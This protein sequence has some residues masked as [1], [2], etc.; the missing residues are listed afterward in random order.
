MEIVCLYDLWLV[1]V[2]LARARGRSMPTWA[3]RLFVVL[4]AVARALPLGTS[5]PTRAAAAICSGKVWVEPHFLSGRHLEEAREAA[6]QLPHTQSRAAR[7]G[8]Q[9]VADASVRDCVLLD[10]LDDQVWSA[11][12]SPLLHVVSRVEELRAALACSTGR[13]LVEDAELQLL[14]YSAGGHYQ[15]H[16]DDGIDTAN[17]PVRRSISLLLYLTPADWH[18]DVDGGALRVHHAG[19]EAPLDVAPSAGSLV[20]FDSATVAHEVLP[21]RR[22]RV[23]I[24]G[25]LLEP[26]D[27]DGNRRSGDAAGLV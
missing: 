1:Y 20:L 14:R 3:A 7:V 17:R 16:I 24:V 10:L 2:D 8:H 15:R 26:R 18:P 25:W 13:P 27:A 6:E 5:L 22:E 19:G 21:T 4:L 9:E 23:V 12:P 11:L